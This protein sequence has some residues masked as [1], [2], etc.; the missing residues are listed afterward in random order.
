[1]LE[2]RVRG[3]VLSQ[4]VLNRT[5]LA[6]QL[7]LSRSA[8][9]ALEAIE[10]LVAVQAQEPNWAYVGL[11]T[12]LA[13]FRHEDLTSLL[14]DRRVVRGGLIRRTKHLARSDD[15]YWLRPLV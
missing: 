14:N 9:S 3:A 7:L 8:C 15:Y 5:L 12:R 13:D 2:G 10:R 11:W 4:R 6:R 1:M